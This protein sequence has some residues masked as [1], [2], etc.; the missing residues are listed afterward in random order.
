MAKGYT[1]KEKIENYILREIDESFD[2]QI[3][4][5][6]ES[7]EQYIDNATG[8]NFK[9]DTVSSVRNYDGDNT[10]LLIVDD[11]VELTQVQIDTDTPLA[12]NSEVY[13]YP[14]NK[15][16][17]NRLK[18]YGGYFPAST[19]GSISVTAKWGYSVD[20]PSDIKFVAMVLVAGIVNFSNDAEGEVQSM[21]IGRYSVTYKTKQEVNDF[22]MAKKILE[23]YKK[24]T[25]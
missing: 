14:L 18:Y 2:G 16:P 8:R 5:W 13:A 6:I 11:F 17:Q 10:S 7:V 1:T 15:K 3:T 25:M 24:Y 22:E 23:Q 19:P 9:A 12:I 4:E 21:S 20:V